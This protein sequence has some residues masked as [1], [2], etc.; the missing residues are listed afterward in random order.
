MIV[1][2]VPAGGLSLRMG[3]PKLVLDFGGSAVIVR[4]VRALIDGGADRVLVVVPRATDPSISKLHDL[5]IDAG[6]TRVILDAQT[7]D[8]RS[9]IEC[10]LK[11]AAML[12]P[13]GVLIAPGDAVG[14]TRDVVASV[15]NRFRADPSRIVVPNRQGKGGHPLALPWDVASEIPR[16]PQGVGVNA[17]VADRV[18]LV[19]A[20]V[21]DLPG[22]DDDLDTPEDYDRLSSM[23]PHV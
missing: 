11:A 1:A 2:I 18:G 9:T 17:I 10:G 21:V 16:L 20:L 8:M 6:A 14:M 15:I 4:V 19:D 5:V 12:A 3:R 7:P 13:S 23:N 22:G